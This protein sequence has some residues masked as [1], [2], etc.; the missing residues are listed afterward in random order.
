M[1]LEQCGLLARPLRAFCTPQN[2]FLCY[3]NVLDP[4]FVSVIPWTMTL[5]L[6]RFH[7]DL[8]YLHC[9]FFWRYQSGGVIEK[10]SLSSTRSYICLIPFVIHLWS[11][12]QN[13]KSFIDKSSVKASIRDLRWRLWIV[14][15]QS[16]CGLRACRHR[17]HDASKLIVIRSCRVVSDP[18]W[19][20]ILLCWFLN[21]TWEHVF[22]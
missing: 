3:S 5:I 19:S 11:T 15:N 8:K 2:I 14:G 4:D 10:V 18:T 16:D 1:R 7:L 9:C 17:L 12:Q 20:W 13:S 22:Y 6:W 21:D